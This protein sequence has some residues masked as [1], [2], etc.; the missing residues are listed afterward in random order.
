VRRREN[1]ALWRRTPLRR[2]PVRERFGCIPLAADLARA[3]SRGVEILKDAQHA[4][5]QSVDFPSKLGL[6]M[7]G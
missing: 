3:M 2:Q 4:I 1:D 7:L 5:V 6:S